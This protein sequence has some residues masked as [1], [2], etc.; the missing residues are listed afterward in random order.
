[1]ASFGVRAVK[2]IKSVNGDGDPK[3]ERMRSEFSDIFE[4]SRQKLQILHK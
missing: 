4:K 3:R 2:S 1:M